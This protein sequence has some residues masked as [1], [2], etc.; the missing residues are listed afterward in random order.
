M[1]Q[2]KFI[3]AGVMIAFGLRT[4]ILLFVY[5]YYHHSSWPEKIIAFKKT[6]PGKIFYND[7]FSITVIVCSILVPLYIMGKLSESDLKLFK[8]ITIGEVS[9]AGCGGKTGCSVNVKISVQGKDYYVFSTLSRQE[10]SMISKGQY[11]TVEYSYKN[12][13][14]ARIILDKPVVLKTDS[15]ISKLATVLEI[16]R[17]KDYLSIFYT[18]NFGARPYYGVR[19]APLNTKINVGEK[20][21]IEFPMSN[22][23]IG[24][25]DLNQKFDIEK[26]IE[27]AKNLNTD[28]FPIEE[29]RD[30]IINGQKV[31]IID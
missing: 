31:Q 18:F 27:S 19:F 23:K 10:V 7:I 21:T 8:H 17:G 4:L 16:K 20:Y 2:F 30:T 9:Y 6:I 15:I 3:G 1:T 25:F 5:L 29:V 14:Y 26:L 13:D 28:S 11:Y 22:P 12:P 24:V